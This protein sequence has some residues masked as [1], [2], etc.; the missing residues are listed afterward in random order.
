MGNLFIR[1]RKWEINSGCSWTDRVGFFKT[2]TNVLTVW[3][4]GASLAITAG[5]KQH[6]LRCQMTKDQLKIELMAC[7]HLKPKVPDQTQV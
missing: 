5:K 7:I 1:A 2:L 3:I 4:N 6:I